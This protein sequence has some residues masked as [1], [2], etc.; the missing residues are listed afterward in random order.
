MKNLF[1][2]LVSAVVLFVIGCQENSI[3]DPIANEPSGKVQSETPDTYY[4]GIILLEAVLKDPYPIGNSYYR[5]SGQIEFEQRFIT[6]EPIRQLSKRYAALT[7][8][9]DASLQYFCTLYPT[10]PEDNLSGFISDVSK[11]YVPIGGNYV[12]CFDKTFKIQG[13]EDGMRLKV[14][15]LVS[16]NG[17]ELNSMWLE[18]PGGVITTTEY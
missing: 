15:F 2:A 17:L 6:G 3:T 7:L 8:V 18:L 4:S 10:S 12:S 9:T 13:R 11:E 16:Q 5:I 1:V 14:R